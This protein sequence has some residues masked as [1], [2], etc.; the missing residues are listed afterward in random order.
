[1]VSDGRAVIGVS[2]DTVQ[3]QADGEQVKA[4]TNY[5]LTAFNRWLRTHDHVQFPEAMLSG[6]SLLHTIAS[7][8]ADA[9]GLSPEQRESYFLTVVATLSGAFSGEIER[10]TTARRVTPTRPRPKGDQP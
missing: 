4:L 3:F 5:L 10:L 2:A 7:D 6:V 9:M 1:M 8:Q